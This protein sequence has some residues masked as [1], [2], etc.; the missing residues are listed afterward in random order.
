MNEISPVEIKIFIVEDDSIFINILSDVVNSVQ[1]Y[2][3]EKN[4]KFI[5]KTFYS[6]KEARYELKQKPD[7]VL[8]DYYITDDVLRPATSDILLKD[9]NSS[10]ENVTVIVVSSVKNREIVENFKKGASFY[11]PKNSKTIERI[12]PILKKTI[13]SIFETKK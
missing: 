3:A 11:V 6:V 10:G 1:N 9:I 4:I 12:I 2:F 5:V 7:I 13:N 8:L